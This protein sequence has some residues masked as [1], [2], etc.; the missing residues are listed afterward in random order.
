MLIGHLPAGYLIGRALLREPSR[1]SAAPLAAIMAGSVLPDIDLLYCYLF[2]H[3]RSH[4][5][6]YWT[7]IPA[8]WLAA[9]AGVLLAWAA[10][11]ELRPPVATWFFLAGVLS[12]LLLDSIIGDIYWLIPFSYQPFSM[13]TVRPRYSPWYLNF[14]MHWVFGLELV[15]VVCAAVLAYGDLR[16]YRTGLSSR[17]W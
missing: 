3:Q 9:C 8:F 16:R 14:V 13:F 1:K 15:L 6:L 10:K 2:D 4:H 11:R 12:H 7:H 5:H 17:H